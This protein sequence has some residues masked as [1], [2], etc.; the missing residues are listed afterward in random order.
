MCLHADHMEF[1]S[2]LEVC[3]VCS[4]MKIYMI[5]IKVYVNGNN[6]T[7]IHTYSQ[8]QKV[9]VKMAAIFDLS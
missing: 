9:L 6:D 3:T 5:Y 4:I 8:V 1:L 7:K 2:F